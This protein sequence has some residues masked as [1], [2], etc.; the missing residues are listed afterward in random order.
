MPPGRGSTRVGRRQG[1]GESRHLRSD[2]LVPIGEAQTN[3][4]LVSA[5]LEEDVSLD[6]DARTV[7]VI[8]CLRYNDLET[9]FLTG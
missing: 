6:L 7:A 8:A 3:G 2:Q 1:N 4:V 5:G 9:V